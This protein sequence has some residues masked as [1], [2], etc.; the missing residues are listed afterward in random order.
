[1]VLLY[2]MLAYVALSALVA[3]LWSAFFAR[4][5]ELV[6]DRHDLD[7]ELWLLLQQERRD[8]AA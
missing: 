3:V 8:Q 4:L 1:M 7:H 6:H 5:K 2:A